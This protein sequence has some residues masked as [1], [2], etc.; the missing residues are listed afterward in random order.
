MQKLVSA[1]FKLPSRLVMTIALPSLLI[2]G[3]C[4]TAQ[5]PPPAAISPARIDGSAGVP[6][7]CT[8]FAPMKFNPGN[9][10]VTAA[11]IAEV[12]AAHPENPLGWARGE[13]GD[14]MSTRA[15]ISGY[16]SARKSLNC[17]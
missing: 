13:L 17:D 10:A 9:P 4:S 2:L 12:M 3:A 14:T 11:D 6:L 16:A 15:A 5:T 8:D 7:A 1:K